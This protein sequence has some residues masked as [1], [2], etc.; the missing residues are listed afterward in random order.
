VNIRILL[1]IL[2]FLLA[3]ALK[4]QEIIDAAPFDTVKP[5]GYNVFHFDNGIVSSEGF[6]KNGKPEGIWKNYYESGKLKSEG[7]RNNHQLD[8][9]WK[10]YSEKQFILLELNYRNGK[11]HGIQKMYYD[12]AKIRSVESYV[13]D[14]RDGVSRYFGPEGK[15]VREVPFK[16]GVEEG[17]AKEYDDE[18]TVIFIST[19]KNGFLVKQQEINR[20]DARGLKQGPWKFFY[21]NSQQVKWE[22]T[23]KNNLKNG[24][25]REYDINGKVIKT[26]EYLNGE[27]VD[28]VSINNKGQ[29]VKMEVRR[30]YYPNAQDRIVGTYKNGVP[31]GVFREYSMEGDVIGSKVY[32]EGKVTGEGILDDSGLEQGHWKYFYYPKGKIKSEGDYKDGKKI[33]VWKYYHENGNLMQIGSYVDDKPEG[34]WKWYYENGKALREETY[35]NGK[36]VGEA[37]EFLDSTAKVITQ[38]TYVDGK[39]E[40]F[41]VY[42]IGDMKVSGNYREGLE[43]GVWKE[44]Y[45]N[46]RLSF[47]GAYV[48]G[49]PNGTHKF[50]YDNG[51]IQEER[52]Y[53][54]GLRDGDWKYFDRDGIKVVTINYRDD[55]EMKI[56]GIRLDAE[57]IKRKRAMKK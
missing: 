25:F 53:R 42:E 5:N 9:T 22:G 36:E 6:M 48:K 38:G 23:F 30:E 43:E 3:G 27:L 50:Y 8:S 32:R 14:K 31:D 20:K 56:D 18:G 57:K 55:K 44:H 10:F 16:E 51:V 26:E 24:T 40:G 41:W 19:Y 37:R 2:F 11:R 54:L 52:N 46:G 7:K 49:E 35:K 4:A 33:G 21:E 28:M 47:E 45:R 12:S 17:L 34:I 15:L 39:K 29:S 1:C 13:D